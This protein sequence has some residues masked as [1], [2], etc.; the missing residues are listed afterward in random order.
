M[1][2]LPKKMEKQEIL[3]PNISTQNIY[4]RKSQRK[5]EQTKMTMM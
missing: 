1:Q 5:K 4:Q 3:Q 2:H